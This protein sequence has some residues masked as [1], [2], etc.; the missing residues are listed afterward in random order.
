MSTLTAP[1]LGAIRRRLESETRTH[2]ARLGRECGAPIPSAAAL[3]L[4]AAVLLRQSEAFRKRPE[5][6]AHVLAEALH[7]AAMAV[8]SLGAVVSQMDANARFGHQAKSLPRIK[9]ELHYE[10]NATL[11]KAREWLNLWAN[12]PEVPHA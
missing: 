6:P 5:H 11:L 4:G 2:I 9:Q 3:Q 8:A 12:S 10:A 1:Q 7:V